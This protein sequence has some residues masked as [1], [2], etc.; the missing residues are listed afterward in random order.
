M[1][2]RDNLNLADPTERQKLVEFQS[3]QFGFRGHFE[4]A[5]NREFEEE[6]RKRLAEE[7]KKITGKLTLLRRAAGL[8]LGLGKKEDE[9]KERRDKMEYMYNNIEELKKHELKY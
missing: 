9:E 6:N 3:K 7:A 5:S 2:L 4:P 1:I 8:T